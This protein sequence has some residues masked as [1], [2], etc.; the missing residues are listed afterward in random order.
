MSQRDLAETKTARV[1][2]YGV[3]GVVGGCRELCVAVKEA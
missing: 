2:E 3:D 1:G